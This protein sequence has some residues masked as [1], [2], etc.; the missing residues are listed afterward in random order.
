MATD[1]LLKRFA[2]SDVLSMQIG[3]HLLRDAVVVFWC[4]AWI[5]PELASVILS[6]VGFEFRILDKLDFAGSRVSFD[7]RF[8]ILIERSRYPFLAGHGIAKDIIGDGSAE[9]MSGDMVRHFMRSNRLERIIAGYVDRCGRSRIV[10]GI[11]AVAASWI[12]D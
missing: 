5:I 3:E 4:C 11:T 12:V 9:P 7:Q 6:F 1:E 8:S 2:V 10:R